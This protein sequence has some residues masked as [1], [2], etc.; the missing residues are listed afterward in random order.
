MALPVSSIERP[1]VQVAVI[2][3]GCRL[4]GHNNSPTALWDFLIH[5]G[6]ADNEPPP[7]RFS[8]SGHY[9][10]HGRPG[11]MKSPGG[12]FIEDVNPAVFDAQFFNISHVDSVAMD[13]Q[14]RQLLE[15]TYEC[16]ENAGIPLEVISGKAVGCLVGTNIVDYA[17]M[18]HRDPE[19][20]P[21]S[22]TIG[23]ASSILTSL[24]AVDVACRYLDKHL[25]DGMLVAGANI[26]LSPEHNE[27]TGMMR[28]TQSA[29]GKCHSFDAKADGYVK[30]EGINCVYLKRLDD[31]IRDGDPIRAVIRGT[32]INSAG[33]TPGIASPSSQAQASAI[34]AAYRNAGLTD[35]DGTTFLECHGTG[36]L[37]GDPIEIDGVAQCFAPTRKKKGQ[38]LIIGSIKSNIGHSEAAAGLSGLIKAVLAVENGLIPGSPTFVIPNP[39][40]DFEASRVRA[41]RTTIKWPANIATGTKLRRA[42]VNSFGFGGANAHAVLENAHSSRHVSSYKKITADFFDDDENQQAESLPTVLVLSANDQQSLEKY[43]QSLSA[44]LINP[45]VS[46]NV[47]DLAFTLNHIKLHDAQFTYGKPASSRPKIGFVFSGQGSQWPQMGLDLIAAFPTARRVILQLDNVLQKLPDRPSWTLLE[48]LIEPRSAEH[49]RQ[50]DICQPSVTA[51]QLAILEVL[52]EWGVSPDCIIGHSS[53]EI[54]AAVAAE[55]ITPEEAIKVAYYR[56]QAAKITPSSEPLGMLAVGLSEEQLQEYTKNAG[57]EIHIACFN[58]PNSLTLSGTVMSLEGLEK[59]LKDDGHFARLL[60]VDLAYHSHFMREIGEVY[61]RMLHSGCTGTPISNKSGHEV[62]MFSSVTGQPLES[63]LG[64]EYWKRNMVSPVRFSQTLSEL[65]QRPTGADFLLEIGPSNTLSAPI[66]Q[67]KKMLSGA[68]GNIPYASAM[69]RSAKSILPLYEAAGQLFLLGGQVNL[70]SV[71]R[72]VHNSVIVDLPNYNWNHSTRYW[73]ETQSSRDW[74][75]KKFIRHDLLGSKMNGTSWHSPTFKQRLLLADLP[76]LRDHKLGNQVIFPAACYIAMAVEAVYQATMMTSWGEK[77]PGRYRYRLR[78]VKFLR[79][80]VLEEGIQTR[81]TLTLAPLRVQKGSLR[82]WYEFCVSSIS[83]LASVQHSTGLICVETNYQ[84]QFIPSAG[85]DPLHLPSQAKSWY[86]AMADSGYNYG[87]CFRNHLMVESTMGKSQSRSTVSLKE[88]PSTYGQSFYPIHPVCIDACFHTGGP[89]VWKGD[90]PAPGVVLVPTLLSSLVIEARTELPAE[91]IALASAHFLGIGDEENP[92]NYSTSCSLYDPANRALLLEFKGLTTGGI[93]AREDRGQQHTL[94]KLSWAADI[95][96]LLLASEQKLFPAL[97]VLELN[98]HPDDATSHWAEN[99][100]SHQ[101]NACSRFD[102]AA[103]HGTALLNAQRDMSGLVFNARFSLLDLSN[104]EAVSPGVHFDL[105]ILKGTFSTTAKENAFELATEKAFNSLSPGGFLVGIS[106]S[107]CLEK[108]GR[109]HHVSQNI[110]ICQ[111]HERRNGLR[112]GNQTVAYIKLFDDAEYREEEFKLRTRLLDSITRHGWDL[113]EPRNLDTELINELLERNG[114]IHISRIVPDAAL[115]CLISDDISDRKTEPADLHETDTMLRL[116]AERLGS[117]DSI[118]WMEVSSQPSPL[119]NGFVQVE[120]YAAG[121]NYKDVIV[122]MGIV[123]GDE[124]MLG[125][126]AAGVVTEVSPGVTGFEIGQRV[127]VYGKGCMAN[128]VYATPGR[129]HPIPEWMTFEEAATVCIAYMTSIY[130]L[131]DLANIESGSRVL[132]HSAS[133]GVFATVGT[134]EKR[135][136]LKSAFGLGDDRVFYSRN[137]DF[138]DQTL[139]VTEGQGVDIVLNSLTGDMLE[140]SFRILADRGTMVDIGKKDILNRNSLPM[141]PF[142]RNISFRSVDMSYERTPE[143]LV[144][145]LLSRLF[146]LLEAGHVKPINPLQCFSFNDLPSA[147]RALR[148]GKHIAVMCRSGYDDDKSRGVIKQVKALGAHIDLLTADVT[149]A[150]QV[151][152]SFKQTTVPVA[153]IIQGAMVLRDRPFDSMTLQEYHEATACKIQGTWN[154]HNTSEKLKLRLDF[155]TML[156]SISG[157]AGTRGQANYA[158]ANVFMDSFAAYRRQQGRPACSVDLG[159]IEDSGFLA[160]KAEFKEIHFDQRVYFGINDRLL[161]KIIELSILKQMVGSRLPDTGGISQIITGLI[162]PQP[163]DSLLARDVRFSA[164]FPDPEGSV[165]G[166]QLASGGNG[167]AEIQALLLLLRSAPRTMDR[168]ALLAAALQVVD[169]GFRRILRLTEP[170]DPTRPVVVYGIDSLAAVEIRNWIRAKLGV[171][172]TTVDIMNASS[173]T[174][175]CEKIL[176]KILGE[177]EPRMNGA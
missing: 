23:V 87:P 155:F 58:S 175:F 100:A 90:L 39:K 113:Q 15:V 150:N 82:H 112:A 170:L 75:F 56:G 109:T 22:A 55:R 84:D 40:I 165:A 34:R 149:C 140:E 26:W 24:V 60:Q 32:A 151:E 166:P 125:G 50:P 158:A 139:A 69:K 95:S 132:I 27:E 53:G 171:N 14:Q 147:M 110:V 154:L 35:F 145:R 1:Q 161:K 94:T 106:V 121:L 16:L 47:G 4:P 124:R 141:E 63:Q 127:V 52:R 172:V 163:A 143:P 25:A 169:K 31:A 103:E 20:R 6:V 96:T 118:S 70:A 129:I 46:L 88:P 7:S 33:R 160:D 77:A 119:Q 146:A 71:N 85:L 133:G 167:D 42:S 135:Q 137:T 93:E 101:R 61:E 36:T 17:M 51:L 38:E 108:F 102:Y 104:A 81:Y 5:G 73:H 3:M 136:F 30:A 144:S 13:P 122:T 107:M 173:L 115:T 44:H 18:Q 10:R 128:R 64:A 156:S 98:L 80:L 123:P 59:R 8:L 153:G 105:V 148:A 174:A 126:E 65:L 111:K 41:I 89:A 54:A 78:D 177:T 48:E 114:V 79:P 130:A 116:G 45:S 11:T 74:R 152:A 99:T 86:K 92:R 43:I 176:A 49:L 83:E 29:S 37:A 159:I 72:N 62:I 120:V 66:T 19:D 21:D 57:G 9:D 131:F 117:V 138:A 168:A 2:G 67:I 142:D 97:K 164:L 12:M 162:T 157:I 134:E 28:M 91:A 76:W 68:A